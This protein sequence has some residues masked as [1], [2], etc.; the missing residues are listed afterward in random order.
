M[1]K[2]VTTARE[3]CE[4]I[5]RRDPE[6]PY[7]AVLAVLIENDNRGNL[8]DPQGIGFGLVIHKIMD[9]D[10]QLSV[11]K[12]GQLFRRLASLP[13]IVALELLRENTT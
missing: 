9:F 7:P 3:G 11:G 13:A 10:S 5:S 8:V 2:A 6:E 1:R 4:L 12:P